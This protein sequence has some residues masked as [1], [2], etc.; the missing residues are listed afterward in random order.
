MSIEAEKETIHKRK[1]DDNLEVKIR[2]DF[3]ENKKRNK[4]NIK[5]T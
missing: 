4:Q 5:K 3:K 2:Q 1:E